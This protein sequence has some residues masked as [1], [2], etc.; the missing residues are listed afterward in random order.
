M[1]KLQETIALSTTKAKYIAASNASKEA[2]QF[3]GLLDEIGRMQ[4]KVN[5]LCDS[6]SAIHLATNPTYH[7]RNKHIDVRYHF[8]R[9]VINGGKVA[10]QKVDT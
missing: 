1:S 5:I 10:V 7:S 8:M 3:K 2:I 6:E 4:E 9:Y